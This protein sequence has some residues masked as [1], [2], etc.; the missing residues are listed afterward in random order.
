MHER[1]LWFAAVAFFFFNYC[2]FYWLFFGIFFPLFLRT[3]FIFPVF[4]FPPFSW[5]RRIKQ[6][7]SKGHMTTTTKKKNVEGKPL[8]L[9]LL[10][11]SRKAVFFFFWQVEKSPQMLFFF[12]CCCCCSVSLTSE[13]ERYASTAAESL[14]GRE[15]KKCHYPQDSLNS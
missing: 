7:S 10:F 14:V 9:F 8:R 11:L 4:F 6:T 13:F 3:V 1:G 5:S 15:K 12:F 2:H